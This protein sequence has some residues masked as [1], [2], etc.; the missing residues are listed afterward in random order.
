MADGVLTV[1]DALNHP[2]FKKARVV[3]GKGGVYKR[4]RWV[5]ILEISNFE[6]L[7]HG[8]EMILA[9][10]IGLQS[11]VSSKVEYLKKLISHGATCLCIEIGHYFDSVSE[12]LICIANEHD[13]P[14]I[15]F[16]ETVRFIDITQ[17]FHSVIINSHHK[18]LSELEQVAFKFN[19]LALTSKGVTN[20]LRL[21][22]E[23]L[24][25]QVIYF[26]VRGKAQ[27][28]PLMETSKQEAFFSAIGPKVN[29]GSKDEIMWKEDGKCYILQQVE[30]ME[31]VWGFVC[32]VSDMAVPGDFE[33]LVLDRA[34]LAIAQDVLR[35]RYIEER[36]LH[37]ENLWV[38][39]LIHNRIKNLEQVKMQM[40]IGMKQTPIQA[41]VCLLEIANL[42]KMET[43]MMEDEAEA[44][45]IHIAL[46]ARAIFEKHCLKPIMT[47]NI[48]QLVM[49][50]IQHETEI[51]LKDKLQKILD[52]VRTT[53]LNKK[54][55]EVDL[56]IAVG[57]EINELTDC[58]TSYEQA[59]QVLKVITSEG[60]PKS[61]FYEDMGV[62]RLLLPFGNGHTM[63]HF[64]YDHIG[65]LIEYDREKGT[66][67]LK[68]LKVFLDHKG[69]KQ[70]S[71]DQ[72][73]IVRQTLYHR[74]EKIKD[75]IGEDFMVSDKRLSIE[76]ALRAYQL[77]GNGQAAVKQ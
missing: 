7:I 60:G 61:Y 67:L 16:R 50:A 13:F 59:Q 41:R 10:G 48:N 46:I 32:L 24:N 14:I 68:T 15:E 62:F 55:G 19:Q 6:T 76:V 25:M 30:A 9:T 2:M 38:S 8:E 53:V 21:L 54:V 27:F 58:H 64:I 42:R 71:A 11:T 5:H 22:Y 70:E 75:L 74:L 3:A 34:V 73:F 35:K 44:L 66:K 26:P 31:Q 1:K 69:S 33:K 36:K 51:L 23:T 12:E 18:M 77:L 65:P 39:D 63:K 17:E 37:N 28:V 57:R 29:E 72:L 47:T 4:I 45:R 43:E 56:N 49:I 52:E 40:G 20:I